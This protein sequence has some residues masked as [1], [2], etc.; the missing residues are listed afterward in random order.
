[1]ADE[2][3]PAKGVRGRLPAWPRN[4]L[5]PSVIAAEQAYRKRSNLPLLTDADIE[6]LKAGQP[7]WWEQEGGTPPPAAASTSAPAAAAPPAAVA[8]TAPSAAP[9]A[10]ASTTISPDVQ[11]MVEAGKKWSKSSIAAE[12]ARRK[13][14]NLRK[15][16]PRQ[17]ARS[18]LPLICAK[19][20]WRPSSPGSGR[21][22]P[23]RRRRIPPPPA[24]R[25]AAARPAR[26]RR[27]GCR[28]AGASPPARW[29]GR[30]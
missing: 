23:G 28:R 6:A 8:A 17:Q 24:P 21:G 3:N 11:K 1:M 5:N 12:N 26:R 14:N 20:G 25:P 16:N 7:M 2:N 29:S 19:H 15:R 27:H 18:W 4:A 13:R 30:R 22:H 10:P 9:A